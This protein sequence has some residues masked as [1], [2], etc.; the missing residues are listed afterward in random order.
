MK[1]LTEAQQIEA[2][3][4]WKAGIIK[5]SQ[6]E[7]W[8]MTI[9]SERPPA[10]RLKR[11]KHFNKSA[12]L[13]KVLVYGTVPTPGWHQAWAQKDFCPLRLYGDA[14]FFLCVGSNGRI[15]QWKDWLSKYIVEENG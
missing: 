8:G 15:R 6:I 9:L 14:R 10:L 2:D 4:S 3:A 1:E 11:L 7:E 13:I 5:T 12:P